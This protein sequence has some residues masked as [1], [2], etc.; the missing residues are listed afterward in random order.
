[1]K[2]ITTIEDKK[3]TIEITDDGVLVDGKPYVVNSQSLPHTGTMS[4]LIN[5][6]SVDAVIES[7]DDG[8]WDVLLE[9]SLYNVQVL[10]ERAW[11][12]SQAFGGQVATT[13]TLTLKSPMPGVV[14]KVQVSEGD[15]IEKG[16]TVVILESMKMENELK[17]SRGGVVYSVHTEDGAVVE[18]GAQLVTIGD[19]EA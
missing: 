10:D 15:L 16:D 1:M 8:T 11:R 4:L 3:Y 6:H 9:G 5:N 14:L 17:A 13:G 18:K 7:G 12:L 19:A 2:Y